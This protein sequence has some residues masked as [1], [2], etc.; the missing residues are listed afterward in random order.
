MRAS[1][2]TS[3]HLCALIL[4]SSLLSLSLSSPYTSRIDK[5]QSS[6]LPL[7]MLRKGCSGSFR[8]AFSKPSGRSLVIPS[9]NTEDASY[10]CSIRSFF[11][12]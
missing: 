3:L 9:R 1:W 6:Y 4:M 8:E 10:G 5:C 12:L 11:D 2:L 7:R